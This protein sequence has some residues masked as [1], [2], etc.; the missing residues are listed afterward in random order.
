MILTKVKGDSK[1]VRKSEPVVEAL[2]LATYVFI[3]LLG[4]FALDLVVAPGID[5][6]NFSLC[7]V[8][9]NN[10]GKL[11]VL[12][13]LN[14]SNRI[15]KDDE[16]IKTIH[17]Q[18]RINRALTR[19]VSIGDCVVNKSVGRIYRT[20]AIALT[21]FLPLKAT[22]GTAVNHLLRMDGIAL[23]LVKLFLGN[24]D[25]MHRVL[26][27]HTTGKEVVISF[28]ADL[29]PGGS[30][31]IGAENNLICILHGID[32]RLVG[33]SAAKGNSV[34]CN[35]GCKNNR[36]HQDTL[37]GNSK[38]AVHNRWK[39]HKKGKG[40]KAEANQQGKEELRQNE[41]EVI[42][43]THYNNHSR[44]NGKHTENCC[45]RNLRP[46]FIL[47]KYKANN[48]KGENQPQ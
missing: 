21:N 28:S 36:S 34:S 2:V 20:E 37:Q 8:V 12:F 47:K 7:N 23:C 1:D 3:E 43:R 42:Y 35:Y 4:I 32:D 40:G 15:A 30:G 27:L 33:E 13:I 6:G 39:E 19:M 22:E 16:K 29:N 10:V 48:S 45:E 31:M 41:I 24:N 26:R 5:N 11:N 44:C 14:H 17:S 9:G 46:F 38:F 18:R 25:L